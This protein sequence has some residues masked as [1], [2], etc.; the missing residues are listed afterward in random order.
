[1]QAVSTMYAVKTKLQEALCSTKCKKPKGVCTGKQSETNKG[2]YNKIHTVALWNHSYIYALYTEFL[3]HSHFHNRLIPT[4]VQTT[5]CWKQPGNPSRR[6]LSFGLIVG[7]NNNVLCFK[8]FA[9]F[10]HRQ[11]CWYTQYTQQHTLLNP[12]DSLFWNLS[13]FS[14]LPHF[15]HHVPEGP[16]CVFKMKR[17]IKAFYWLD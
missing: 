5:N 13:R 11:H 3:I 16:V 8:F 4:N 6:L 1:M 10:Y 12:H 15:P 9:P 14:H 7:G 17:L 2:T